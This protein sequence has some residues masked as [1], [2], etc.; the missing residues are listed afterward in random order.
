M[1]FIY[2]DIPVIGLNILFKEYLEELT[3]IW[4]CNVEFDAQNRSV[5]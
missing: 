3:F 2:I 4:T 5:Q 1:G